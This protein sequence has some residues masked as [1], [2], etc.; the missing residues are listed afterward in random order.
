MA[1]GKSRRPWYIG[2]GVGALAVLAVT[3]NATGVFSFVTGF[4]SLRDLFGSPPASSAPGEGVP[5]SSNAGPD[6]ETSTAVSSIALPTTVFGFNSYGH[7]SRQSHT[8]YS[9]EVPGA[10]AYGYWEN[11]DGIWADA[12]VAAGSGGLSAVSDKQRDA[13]ASGQL[14]KNFGSQTCVWLQDSD[15]NTPR[16]QVLCF[17]VDQQR[18]IGM[19]VATHTADVGEISPANFANEVWNLTTVS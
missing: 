17:R 14:T 18:G 9:D 13:E 6:V 15:P 19:I 1:D 11:S 4:D 3:A 7:E 5:P 12:T 10:Y 2:L 8:L 16:H